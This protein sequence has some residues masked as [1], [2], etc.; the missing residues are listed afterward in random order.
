MSSNRNQRAMFRFDPATGQVAF[1]GILGA[2]GNTYS[3]RGRQLFF[4]FS[5]AAISFSCALTTTTDYG[6]Q[7]GART[8]QPGAAPPVVRRPALTGTLFYASPDGMVK[9]TL[10]DGA[11]S[12]LS[13]ASDFDVRGN[14]IIFVTPQSTVAITSADGIGTRPLP[15]YGNSNNTPR[16]APDGQRVVLM[17]L[18]R[19]ASV[20]EAAMAVYSNATLQ[21]MI[22]GR[23]GRPQLAFSTG[24][25]QPT[26]TP[27][28]RI[29]VA[30]TKA[31]GSL[32]G[33]A[34]TGIFL[35]AA[36]GSALRRIDP[37]F[38]APHSPAVSPDGSLVA[39]V[40]ASKIWVM[41]LSG[42]TPRSLYEG[43]SRF[44]G[45]LA[46]SPDGTIIAFAEDQV[47]KTVSQTGV[48]A[49]IQDR[50]GYGVRSIGSIVWR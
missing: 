39:F 25:S 17:G 6:Q 19:P 22:V 4:E 35:S 46:W 13:R 33:D 49:P 28:G 26:W 37:G 32:G 45:S 18:Q 2:L 24:Y 21:P 36:R 34:Q 14:D 31:L 16:F 41:P 7:T 47:L 43:S 23:D 40:N 30:G 27:D 11:S 9:M 3:S 8:T 48:V 10:A 50:G 1:G 38:D 5:S 44:L 42:G 12:P 15:V 20:E 29:V